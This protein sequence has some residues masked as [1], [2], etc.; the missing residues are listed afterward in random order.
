MTAEHAGEGRG[1]IW[2]RYHTKQDQTL[3]SF[4]VATVTCVQL[5]AK[6]SGRYTCCAK[7]VGQAKKAEVEELHAHRTERT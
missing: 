7:T 5:L 1:R 4:Q 6:Y 3:V 2:G